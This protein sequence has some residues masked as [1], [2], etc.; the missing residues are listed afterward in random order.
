MTPLEEKIIEEFH[1]KFFEDIITGSVKP[2][3]IKE[4]ILN[5]MK[6][7]KQEAYQEIIDGLPKGMKVPIEKEWFDAYN[8]ESLKSYLKVKYLNK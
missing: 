5:A 7:V 1:N 3:D 2:S 8:L 6:Q 4:F